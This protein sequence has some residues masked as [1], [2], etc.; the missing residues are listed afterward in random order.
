MTR[1]L[2][3]VGIAALAVVVVTGCALL[4]DVGSASYGA[5]ADVLHE[6]PERRV[7]PHGIE[8]A[9]SRGTLNYIV[10][11]EGGVVLVDAG[12]EEDGEAILK[13]LSGRKVLAVLLTHAHIDH[14]AAA[15]VFDAPVY[16]G[17][18]DLPWFDDDWYL[19]AIGPSAG[20]RVW[21]KPPKPKDL[22]GVT[23]QQALTVGGV[24]FTAHSVP[25][26]TPGST[27]W[28]YEDVLFTGDAVQSPHGADLYPAPW[29]VTEDR[30]QAWRSMRPLLD[31]DFNTLL[32]GHYGRADDAKRLLRAAVRGYDDEWPYGYPQVRAL[33]C[34]ESANGHA[35]E[36]LGTER[37]A[38]PSGEG[39]D[40]RR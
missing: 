9:C 26:H 24:R 22:R 39:T 14:R 13:V 38:L 32:D 1:G 29:T 12:F 7:T 37:G 2:S 11:V 15:H 33:G 18:G 16:V 23:D 27:A 34:A 36:P 20:R 17:E 21:D 10:P 3:L 28:Q 40:A 19:H 30:R 35:A 5:A 25:G 4:R 8:V 6:P 31:V